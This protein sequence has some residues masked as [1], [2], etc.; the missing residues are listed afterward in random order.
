MASP[1]Y[2]RPGSPT[3]LVAR[4]EQLKLAMEQWYDEHSFGARYPHWQELAMID[5]ELSVLDS[6]FKLL[7]D[8]RN[9]SNPQP[10]CLQGI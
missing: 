4:R 6:R 8:D 10:F 1:G 3:P 9:C 2:R 7:W 5:D